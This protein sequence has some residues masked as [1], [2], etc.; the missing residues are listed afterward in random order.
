MRQ[1]RET[2]AALDLRTAAIKRYQHERFA[3]DYGTLLSSLRYG[4][5]A[6]F[7]LDELYGPKDFAQR[8][9]QFARVVPAMSRLLPSEVMQTVH[10]LGALHALTEDL[11]HEMAKA[12][13]DDVV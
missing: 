1:E 13:T 6:R 11:D 7:F 12:L 4:P 2:D 9:A 3:R 10:E 8:D 5:A